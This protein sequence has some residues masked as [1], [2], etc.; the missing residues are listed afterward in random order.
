[1]KNKKDAEPASYASFERRREG[2]EIKKRP[3]PPIRN[4]WEA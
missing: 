3:N 2:R 4:L 1:M